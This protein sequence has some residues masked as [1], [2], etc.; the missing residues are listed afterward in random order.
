[1]HA[2]VTYTNY[3]LRDAC[4]CFHA[5]LKRREREREAPKAP[6]RQS[7]HLMYVYV[8]GGPSQPLQAVF[9]AK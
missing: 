8:S 3:M 4:I 9:E 5:T 7:C 6:A 1:M 2:C